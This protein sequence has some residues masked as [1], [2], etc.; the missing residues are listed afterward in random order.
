MKN[1]VYIKLWLS[2][3]AYFETFS[4]AEVGR[5]VR[6]MLAYKSTGT[7]PEFRGNERFIWP[8]IKREIDE[9]IEKQ[10]AFSAKQSENGKKGGRP[11]KADSFSKKPKNPTLFSETQKSQVKGERIE[12]KGERLKV[13]GEKEKASLRTPQRKIAFSPPTLKEVTDYCQERNNGIDPQMFIDFYEARGWKYNGGTPMKDWKAAVRTWEHR[14][15]ARTSP[16]C[17]ERKQVDYQK[18][19]DHPEL[20]EGLSL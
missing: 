13:E 17:R 5:L 6:A 4:D 7:E 10:E 1:R 14:Q 2:Y 9:D 19:E 18:Y 20:L 15:Q 16:E 12:E 11:P 8:A 3:S